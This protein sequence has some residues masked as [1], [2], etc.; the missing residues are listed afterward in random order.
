MIPIS[1]YLLIESARDRKLSLDYIMFSYLASLICFVPCFY[2]DKLKEKGDKLHFA[3]YACGWENFYD[4][5]T[6]KTLHIMLMRASRP[7]SIKTV[8]RTVCL[9]TFAELCKQAYVIF[10]MMYAVLE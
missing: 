3:I 10:N 8:F 9:E 1:L 4:K 5:N 6:R 2:S 7:L